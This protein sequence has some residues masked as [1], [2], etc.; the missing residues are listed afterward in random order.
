ME[1]D[2]INQLK[3]L[4]IA[5]YLA[6]RGFQPVEQSNHRLRYYSPW[7][8]ESTP[9]FWV[10]QALNRYKDFGTDEKGDD[11]I[12]LLMRLDGC[13]FRTAIINLQHYA[14]QENRPRFSFIGPSLSD[15]TDSNTIRSVKLLSNR[16]L[17]NYVASRRISYSV[18]RQYLQEVYYHHQNTNYFALGFANDKGGYVLRSSI[19]KR[20]LGPSGITTIAVSGST[21]INLFEGFFDFLSALE[22]YQLS[23]P[24]CTTIVLNSTTNLNQALPLLQLTKQVNTY[25]DN[26]KAGRTAL[27]A[28]QQGGIP[29]VDRSSLYTS[30]KDL[31]AFLIASQTT[32]LSNKP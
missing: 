9:S 26:D 29:C 2:Q 28:L 4:P 8:Q 16:S 30:H 19:S 14:C 7:R 23:K 31:N 25:L 3:Q 10:D 13:D 15:S 27:T 12:Q 18:A 32:I 22:Y 17:M 20:N 21:A 6:Y 11:L 24:R 5:D 1:R